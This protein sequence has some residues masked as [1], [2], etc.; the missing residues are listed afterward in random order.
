[1]TAELVADYACE[2]GEGP[3]WHP[4]EERL[5]WADIPNGTLYRYDPATDTHG[6]VL[7]DTVV[8]GG[9]IQSDG[10]L[11]LFGAG[12]AVYRWAGAETETVATLDT[13]AHTRFNDV[14]ADPRGRVFCGTMP[15]DD[16]LG[17]LFRLD[18]DGTFTRILDEVDI[19]NGMA[20]S[21]DRETFYFTASDENAIYA[22]DY[23]IESGSISDRSVL[24]DTSDEA[25]VPDGLAIDERGDLWSARWGGNAVVRYSPEGVE[26]ERVDVPVEKVSCATFGGPSF[27]T[28]YVTTAGGDERPTGGEL[29]GSLFRYEP[30]TTGGAQFYSRV[31]V[32]E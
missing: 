25:G 13:A 29:D 8:S 5:Y 2:I 15:T 28:L 22:F 11:L 9:T 18:R 20:F 26:R 4:D 12:G 14:I 7:S 30:D 19:P 31:L 21:A 3:V 6:T 24:V 17:T 27:D 32:D 23:D 1:M 10:S 16:Q